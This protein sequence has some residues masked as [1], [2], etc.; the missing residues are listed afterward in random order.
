MFCKKGEKNGPAA[1]EFLL[2]RNKQD[3]MAEAS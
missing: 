3:S 2:E 1:K